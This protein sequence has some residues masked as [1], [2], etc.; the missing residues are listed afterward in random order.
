ME[1]K[2]KASEADIQ[3]AILDYLRLKKVFHYRNNSGAAV[4]PKADGSHRFF[5]FGAAGSPD[6]ICV[7]SGQYI[8]LEV[9]APKAKLSETQQTFQDQLEKAG[10]KYFVVRS[11][12]EVAA[13]L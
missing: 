13:I 9:K 3:R 12:E 6:I 8:G 4:I 7:V 10:G 2:D 5:R 11:V 1:R